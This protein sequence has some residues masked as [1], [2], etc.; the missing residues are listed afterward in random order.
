MR[1]QSYVRLNNVYET[2]IS[3]LR[4]YDPNIEL[5]AYNWRLDEKSY[6]KLMSV[7]LLEAQDYPSTKSIRSAVKP[8]NTVIPICAPGPTTTQN[9]RN[10]RVTIYTSGPI[11][12][13]DPRNERIPTC[14]PVRETSSGPQFHQNPA[15]PARQHYGNV[16]ADRA[17]QQLQ[18][19]RSPPYVS[20]GTTMELPLP[21]PHRIRRRESYSYC[22]C[23]SAI[24]FLFCLCLCW[25]LV[26]FAWWLIW[27]MFG[28]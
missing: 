24:A 19:Q 27:R 23:E 17:I 28:V 6:Y 5:P 11:A 8:H 13:Q 15:I 26:G 18:T 22:L 9:L 25:L 12:N 1:K 3:S 10:A 21:T 7:L 14:A 2:N 4:A 20:Y 16:L